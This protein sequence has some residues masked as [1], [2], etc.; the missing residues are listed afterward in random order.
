MLQLSVEDLSK[1][2]SLPLDNEMKDYSFRL[3]ANVCR[4]PNNDPVTTTLICGVGRKKYPINGDNTEPQSLETTLVQWGL[5]QESE[6]IIETVKRGSENLLRRI[7]Y[8]ENG[9]TKAEKGGIEAQTD[10]IGKT[11][12]R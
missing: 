4:G 2:F 12:I 3:R 11:L 5:E 1:Y 7:I 9:L 8:H 6:W 10:V